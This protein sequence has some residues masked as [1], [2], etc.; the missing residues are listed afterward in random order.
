M[1]ASAL[2]VLQGPQDAAVTVETAPLLEVPT[3][4][5]NADHLLSHLAAQLCLIFK[6]F[7]MSVDNSSHAL[8]P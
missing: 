6:P 5:A 4:Q 2:G 8:T 1:Q 7:G 3:V